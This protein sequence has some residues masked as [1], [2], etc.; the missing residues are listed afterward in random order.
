[1]PTPK[2][3]PLRSDRIRHPPKEGWS[4]IDRRFIRDK[5][6]LLD[7]DTILLYFFLAAV[8]DK[9]GLSYWSDS[10]IAEVL[11]LSEASVAR[12]REE[13]EFQDLIAYRRPIYQVLSFLLPSACRE[14][15]GPSLIG[16]VFR[17]L[18]KRVQHGGNTSSPRGVSP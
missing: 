16:D 15:A 18:A 17:E 5:I 12:A 8:A 13:L 10:S 3:Y 7:R 1:M 6:F 11:R 9:H 2:K 4:W 14:S